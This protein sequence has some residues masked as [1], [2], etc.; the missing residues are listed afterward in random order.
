MECPD[1]DYARIAI[2]MDDWVIICELYSGLSDLTREEL[3]S[4]SAKPF[5]PEEDTTNKDLS[6][7][8]VQIRQG[9]T[10]TEIKEI[11]QDP[12]KPYTDLGYMLRCAWALPSGHYLL[13]RF[14]KQEVSF[15]ITYS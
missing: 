12:G 13:V 14:D 4:F 6:D 2:K 5:V 7:R 10:Y 3:W 9:M 8:V 15:S 1:E 11:L